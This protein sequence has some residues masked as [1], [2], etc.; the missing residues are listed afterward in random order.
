MHVYNAILVLKEIID[1]FPLASVNEFAGSYVDRVMQ[2]LV[3]NE[4]RGDLKILGRAY[5]HR[6]LQVYI[7]Q[8][9]IVPTVTTPA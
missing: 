4:E 3:Q 2:R 7:V 1:V 6:S 8:L 9:L 5:V